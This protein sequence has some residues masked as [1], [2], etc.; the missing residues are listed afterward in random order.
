MS[1]H[2]TKEDI[3]RIDKRLD[4]VN[5]SVEGMRAQN[6]AEHG[7]IASVVRSALDGVSWLKAA[8]RRFTILPAPPPDPKLRSKDDTQ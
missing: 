8:W 6:S 7:A 2:A 5:K 3:A 4:E 1:D